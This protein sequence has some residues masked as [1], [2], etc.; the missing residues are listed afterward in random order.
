M[1][2]RIK[3]ANDAVVTFQKVCY[4][5]C[6]CVQSEEAYESQAKPGLMLTGDVWVSQ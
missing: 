2:A 4:L 5:S 1:P 3:D 6:V